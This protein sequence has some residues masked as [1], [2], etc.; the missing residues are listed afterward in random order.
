MVVAK[1]AGTSASKVIAQL[2]DTSPVRKELYALY[3]MSQT[4]G[5][6]AKQW[7][8][9]IPEWMIEICQRL[10]PM[11]YREEVQTVLSNA[12]ALAC[13]PR[14]EFFVCSFKLG[15]ELHARKHLFVLDCDIILK[16]S[17]STSKQ[18]DAF[19]TMMSNGRAVETCN[20]LSWPRYIHS[21][22][23]AQQLPL[24]KV[25][26]EGRVEKGPYQSWRNAQNNDEWIAQFF[27]FVLGVI[28]RSEELTKD[29]FGLSGRCRDTLMTLESE[30]GITLNNIYDIAFQ[31][32]IGPQVLVLNRL[33]RDSFA[34]RYGNTPTNS[35]LSTINLLY[36][37]VRVGLVEY[38][39]KDPYFGWKK[40]A[41]DNSFKRFSVKALKY[42]DSGATV[43]R[44]K[45]TF[46]P[47]HDLDA[48]YT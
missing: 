23:L 14:N 8:K 30:G 16:T 41:N 43:K 40:N 4:T 24:F 29:P 26:S 38:I 9:Q 20:I 36:E 48:P 44:A 33:L 7:R 45:T 22:D 1:Y 2:V 5:V 35:M 28:G 31:Q 15:P 25:N 13:L 37:I 10:T 18:G 6:T 21:A 12:F 11:L 34:E 39:Q 42:E 32:S 3:G 19:I 17:K 47:K 27:H 46:R